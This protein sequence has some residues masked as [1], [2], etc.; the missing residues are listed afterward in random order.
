MRERCF[1]VRP[2]EPSIWWIGLQ[3]AFAIGV[4]PI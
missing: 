3:T 2:I 1:W 4:G